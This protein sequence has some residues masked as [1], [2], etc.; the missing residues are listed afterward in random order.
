MYSIGVDY[1]PFIDIAEMDGTQCVN[2]DPVGRETSDY[3]SDPVFIDNGIPVG[4]RDEPSTV[5]YVS[6]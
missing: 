3:F 5:L 6:E 1:I 4:A 2:P